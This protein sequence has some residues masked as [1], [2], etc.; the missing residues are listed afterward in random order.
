[1]HFA[2]APEI[3]NDSWED[4]AHTPGYWQTIPTYE[5]FFN[6]SLLIWSLPTLIFDSWP[7]AGNC[8]ISP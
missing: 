1:M 3:E 6:I 2:G 5:T 8:S 7:S 4:P